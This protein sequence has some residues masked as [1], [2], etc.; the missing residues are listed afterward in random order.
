MHEPPT[1]GS[2]RAGGAPPAPLREVLVVEDN[3]V[4]QALVLALLARAGVPATLAPDGEVALEHL[5]ARRWA[6]V[7]MDCEM[8]VLDGFEATRRWRAIEAQ[9]GLP[10]TPV[11]ALTANAAPEDR[12]RCLAA[13]MDDVLSKPLAPRALAAL[14]K[15]LQTG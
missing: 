13:G 4:N 14:L 5:R 9:R 11:I 10:R 12:A 8:P 1:T 7:L 6:L 15:Q 2:S 3:V